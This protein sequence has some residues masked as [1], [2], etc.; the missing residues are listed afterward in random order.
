M[1]PVPMARQGF[2]KGA[3]IG[4]FI[5]LI[6]MGIGIYVVLVNVGGFG[7]GSKTET[8][9]ICGK[10]AACCEKISE[11]SKNKGSAE[12][13]KNLR[14]LGVPDSVCQTSYDTFKESAKSLKVT[15]E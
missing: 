13:C 1:T 7:L 14:K 11:A 12:N 6:G 15:C 2:P 4:L 8:D 3:M 5:G 9:S 10:A